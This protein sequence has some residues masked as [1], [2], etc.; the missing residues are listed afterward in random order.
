MSVP[1]FRN[2]HFYYIVY[3]SPCQRYY[4]IIYSINSIYIVIFSLLYILHNI[5]L[6]QNHHLPFPPICYKINLITDQILTEKG[7]LE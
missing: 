6:P 2:S 1:A 3:Y 7:E 5:F 4:S